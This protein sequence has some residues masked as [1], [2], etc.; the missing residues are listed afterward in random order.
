MT[1]NFS[2][3]LDLIAGADPE[4]LK[5]GVALCRPPWFAGEENPRFQVV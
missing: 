5:K 1:Y 4:I 3:I 2:K